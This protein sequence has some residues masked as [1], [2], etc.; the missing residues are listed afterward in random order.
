MIEVYTIEMLENM[1]LALPV[2]GVV[3]TL[4]LVLFKKTTTMAHEVALL[5]F[6]LYLVG[7][8]TVTLNFLSDGLSTTPMGPVNMVLLSEIA[9]MMDRGAHGLVNIWGNVLLF[10]P[11]G[12]IIPLMWKRGMAVH[13]VH[14]VWGLLPH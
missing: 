9:A 1:I 13:F 10:L 6:W 2:M 5:I 4:W 11:M 3:R 12:L 14:R 7:V 8:Y